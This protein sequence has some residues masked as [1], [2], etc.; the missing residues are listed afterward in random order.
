MGLA[1]GTPLT[2]ILLAC[3]ALI[4]AAVA[5]AFI[6][7][8]R[9]FSASVRAIAAAIARMR[10]GDLSSSLPESGSGDLGLLAEAVNGLWGEVRARLRTLERDR[11]TRDAM[12]SALDEAVILLDAQDRVLYQ[13]PAAG[14]LLGTSLKDARQVAPGSIRT[15]IG[16]ARQAGRAAAREVTLEP[17]GRTLLVNAIGLSGEGTVL[18]VLRDVTEARTVDAVRRDFVANASHE[19]RTPVASIQALAE[20][21]VSAAVDDPDSVARFGAQLEG[22]ALR[23][24]RIVSDLLDLSRLE[25]GASDRDEI[26]LDRLVLEEAGVYRDRAEAA[27]LSMGVEVGGSVR[28]R[29]S[30]RDLALLVRNLIENAIQYTRSGGRVDVTV[31][32]QDDG[33][34]VEVRDTGVGIPSRDRARVFERFFRVDRARSRETGGTGLGLSIVKHVAENH[35]G[36]VALES[37]LGLGSTFTVRLPA[38]DTRPSDASPPRS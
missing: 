8:T 35:G 21:V 29:G 15:L 1:V 32:S 26:R 38:V 25:G 24:S 3:A 20:T 12:L 5:I 36:S 18:V 2:V 30:T 23:L 28:V 4:G 11:T 7:R 16:T 9:R 10:E 27:G 14:S 17:G 34:I 19:L 33:A 31:R 37:E 13:N 22:E 6:L